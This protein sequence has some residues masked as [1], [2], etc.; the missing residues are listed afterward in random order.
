MKHVEFVHL[1]DN[2]ALVVMIT[3]DGLVENRIIEIPAGMPPSSLVEAGNYLNSRL[4]GQTLADAK[5]RILEELGHHKVNLDTLAEKVVESGLGVWS[6][7]EQGRALIIKGQSNLLQNVTVEE[8]LNR[9]RDLF[10][11]LDT[12]ER[13]MTLLDASISADCVQ[14]FIGAENSLFS[15]AGCSLVVAPYQNSK[16]QI[17]GAIGVVG[18]TRMDYGK[19]IPL[20]DYT[21]KLVGR[22]LG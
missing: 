10:G 21:A 13:L 20:V 12:K 4:S 8:D 17:L 18:P 16:Q 2:R 5:L 14:I 22:L 3:E 6:N 9:I 15:L 11:I 19:I 7:N 1:P